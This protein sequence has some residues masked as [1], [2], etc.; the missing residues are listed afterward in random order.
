MGPPHV[1]DDGRRPLTAASTAGD[2]VGGVLTLPAPP[3][4]YNEVAQPVIVGIMGAHLDSRSTLVG[5][6]PSPPGHALLDLS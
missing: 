5:S 1:C 6:Q 2:E 4:T 3:G